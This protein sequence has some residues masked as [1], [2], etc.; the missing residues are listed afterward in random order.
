M[1]INII[2]PEQFT[3][4]PWKNG[5]GKTTQ[6]AISEG[7]D[8][9]NFDWRLSIATVSENGIFSDFSGYSRNLVLISGKG[10]HLE[11]DNKKVDQLE[12][13]LD[14]ASFDGGCKTLGKLTSGP[15]IDFNIMTKTA[16]YQAQVK[17]YIDEQ[18][19]TLTA[20]AQYFVYGLSQVTKLNITHEDMELPTGYLLAVSK[21]NKEEVVIKGANLIVIQLVKNT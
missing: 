8:L 9:A 18:Y 15:I 1:A 13:L 7:G 20:N 17:R 12:Q 2:S 5:Q 4:I 14:M 16:I 6:L 3:T 19:I 21:D 10:I 11:H